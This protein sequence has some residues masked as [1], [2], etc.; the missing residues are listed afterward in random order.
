MR[1]LDHDPAR[2]AL[3]LER[4]EPG[5]HLSTAGPEVALEVL[6]G[7]LPRLWLPAEDGSFTTLA[8]E[9][10]WWAAEMARERIEE[11]AYPGD[12]LD[13]A[14]DLASW[15]PAD[16]GE[17]VLVHQDL[18]GDNVVAA[19]REP[20]LAID[21]KPLAGERAFALAP[22]VRSSELGHSREQVVGR[23][24]RLS[25]AF[26]LDRE[27]VRCWTIAQTV[28]WADRDDPDPDHLQVVRWLI[29]AA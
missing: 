17:Q 2:R 4:A 19:T 25:R 23:L 18:H 29:E 7:L 20:W 14:I 16:Q 15:L 5:L 22:I 12:L 6:L 8:D 1:L 3:L 11:H 27:R 26:D 9:A 13:L 24:D 21:P 28:A 10:A